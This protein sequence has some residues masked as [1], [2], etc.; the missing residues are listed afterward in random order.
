MAK[1]TTPI[2]QVD[3]RTLTPHPENPRRGDVAGVARSIT[4][5]GWWG[6][7]IAQRST[8]RILAGHTRTSAAIEVGLDTIP[9]YWLDVDDEGARRILLA[10]NRWADVA[11]YDPAGLAVLLR[12][13]DAD[14]LSAV[15]YSSDDLAAIESLLE[16]KGDD[17]EAPP[18]FPSFDETVENEVALIECPACSHRFPPPQ[19]VRPDKRPNR[20]IPGVR[21]SFPPPPED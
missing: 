16:F 21:T 11:T 19:P 7:V 9:V 12:E 20:R 4:L 3:P 8:G 14:A 6:V 2:E 10:D 15:G 5:N 18:E 17:P 13:L 1:T